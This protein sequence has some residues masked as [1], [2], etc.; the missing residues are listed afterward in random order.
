MSTRKHDIKVQYILARWMD[1]KAVPRTGCS[2]QKLSK[3][4]IRENISFCLLL[5]FFKGHFRDMVSQGLDSK[6]PGSDSKEARTLGKRHGL[7]LFITTCPSG[8]L[9]IKSH[10]GHNILEIFFSAFSSTHHAWG[11]HRE[12]T[13]RSN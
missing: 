13:K 2:N 6:S 12:K 3:R 7:V 5:L 10:H 9:W 4:K 8:G 1:E 11:F